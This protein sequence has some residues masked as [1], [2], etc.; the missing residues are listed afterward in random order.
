MVKT[1]GSRPGRRRFGRVR[2]LP[3]GR[4]Q[5]GYLA[6]DN[7][8]I[9]AEQTFHTKASADRW[10]MLTE[11]ALVGGTWTS[12]ERRRE[13]VGE[14]A[15]RWLKSRT[16]L[17]V[18]TSEL[19]AHLLAQH[20]IP[21]LGTFTLVDLSPEDVRTWYAGI[22]A[23]HP[24]TAAKA[25]RLL[26]SVMSRAV[27]DG[28]ISRS[29][30]RI[31]GAGNEA[32]APRPLATLDEVKA[33]TAAMPEHLRIIVPLAVWCQLRR[34]E[35]LGLQ[36][37]DFGL[38]KGVLRVT[39]TRTTMMNGGVVV[40]EPKTAAGRRTIAIPP[41]VIPAIEDHLRRYVRA[42]PA[43]WVVVGEKG[44]P[45]QATHLQVVWQHAR[46]SLDRPDLHFHDLRHTGLTWA[47]MA[48]ATT[49]ELMHRGG[50]ASPSAALRYQHAT[51]ERDKALAAALGELAQPE[52]P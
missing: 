34:G 10:L 8:V 24:S 7:S 42:E 35:I 12:P 48:G 39:R 18:R 25:Y 36:R 47:A 31:P 11:S 1:T 28:T 43:A 51:K 41:P 16:G 3:S 33:L 52:E 49:A 45:L 27:D 19:Y 20:I 50:H 29:P 40:K 2:K 37:Q 38:D 30:C 46:T 22:A 17:A 13:T 32:A 15:E 4:Y 14:W 23:E 21:A 26:S 9:Y 5:A 44:G 6:P